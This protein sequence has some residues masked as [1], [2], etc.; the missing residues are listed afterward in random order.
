M[1]NIT[2]FPLLVFAFSFITMSTAILITHKIFKREGAFEPGFR[3]TFNLVQGS[4]LSLLALLIGFSF[5]MSVGNYDTR[6]KYEEA[7]AKAINTAYKRFDF[8]P[9]TVKPEAKI[10]LQNYLNLRI[11]F[12]QTLNQNKQQQINNET[13]QKGNELWQ[14]LNAPVKEQ[15][16]AVMATVVTSVND[17]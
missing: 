11:A 17:V 9:D 16:T 6:S 1:K 7:E 13:I 14:L 2:D 10:T 8:L 4:T 3:E 12:Y 15:Q 5:S